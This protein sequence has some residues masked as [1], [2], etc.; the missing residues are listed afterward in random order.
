M[1]VAFTQEFVA[2]IFTDGDQQDIELSPLA[3]GNYV[4]I[5]NSTGQN[6]S[7]QGLVAQLF[8]PLGQRIGGEF[9]VETDTNGDQTAGSVTGLTGGGFVVSWRDGPSNEIRLQQFNADGTPA[10][11]ETTVAVTDYSTQTNPTVVALDDGGYS[12]IW[13]S[14]TLDNY[15]QNIVSQRYDAGGTPSGGLVLANTVTTGQQTLPEV[16]PLGSGYITTWLSNGTISAQRFNADGSKIGAEFTV[17]SAGTV[18]EPQVVTLAGGRFVIVW[19]TTDTDVSGYTDIAGRL[20]EADGSPVGD[21][22]K[23]NA[24]DLYHQYSPAVTA[25]PDGGFFVS[26]YTDT[27]DG[28]HQYEIL[29]QK[30]DSDGSPDPEGE[31]QLTDTVSYYPE[32]PSIIALSNGVI[33][34]AWDSPAVDS[35][36]DG[37]GVVMRLFT[38]DDS[39]LVAPQAPIVEG[40]STHLILDEADLNAGSVLLDSAVAV[41]DADNATFAG[42]MITLQRITEEDDFQNYQQAMQDVL[43][44]ANHGTGAGQIGV[45]GSTVSYEGVVIGTIVSN[46]VDGLDLAISLTAAANLVSVEA[47]IEALTYA[48]DSNDPNEQ[49]KLALLFEDGSGGSAKPNIITIDITPEND[50]AQPLGEGPDLV[51]STTTSTQSSPDVAALADGGWI[52]V[53]ESN[54]QDSNSYGIY[55]QRYDSDGAHVGPEF[56][57]NTTVNGS[58][59]TPSVAGIEGGPNA[60][61]WVITWED[62]TGSST[63]GYIRA[64][65]YD[66]NGAEVGPQLDVASD[67]NIYGQYTPEVAT[68]PD[69][70]FVVTWV[71]YSASTSNYDIRAQR[72]DASGAKDGAVIAVNVNDLSHQTNPVISTL[73][74]GG[75]VVTW[76]D[77]YGYDGDGYGVRAR[78][79]ADDGTPVSAEIAVNQSVTSTQFQPSVAALDDGSFV[80]A[81]ADSVV[82][83]SSYAVLGQK[84]AADG[85]TIGGQFLVNEHTQNNQQD[86]D[87]SALDGGGFMI[88][89]H[90][91]FDGGYGIVSQSYDASG[92]RID[93]EIV[94]DD[95]YSP[96]AVALARL[97]GG[98]V[99]SVFNVNDDGN[100]A[101]IHQRLIGDEGS[102]SDPSDDPKLFGFNSVRNVTEAEVNANPVLLDANGAVAL[103]DLN[104]SDFDGGRLEVSR[105]TTETY[106]SRIPAPDGD[107]QHVIGIQNEGNGSGQI[108][109]IGSSV[110]YGG[111]V[112]GTIASTNL[113]FTVNFNAGATV[114][115]V[116]TLLEHL[117]YSNTS[118]DPQDTRSFRIIL[119][120]GDGG[121]ATP[122]IVTVEIEPEAEGLAAA[123]DERLSNTNSNSTQRHPDVAALADGGYVVVWESYDQDGGITDYGIFAQQYGADGTPVGT[124]FQVTTETAG[125]QLD[126]AVVGLS[127][128]GYVVTWGDSGNAS[129]PGYDYLRAQV[130][131]AAGTPVGAEFQVEGPE[132]RYGTSPEITALSGGGF[133]VSWR[134]Y[135]LDN[136]YDI[137]VQRFDA[138]GTKVGSEV[139]VSVAPDSGQDFSSIAELTNGNL[140]VVWADTSAADGNA[141][142]VIGQIIDP[143]GAKVG[144]EFVVN[145]DVENNQYEASVAAL[146]TG[147][148]V[149]TWRNDNNPDGAG[150]GIM[151]Q[152]FA[153]DGSP[154]GEEFLV[155][156]LPANT[157]YEPV[158]VGQPGGGFAIAYTSNSGLDSSGYGIVMQQYAADGSRIDG[159]VLVNQEQHSSQDK[160]AI[161]VLAD[162]SLVIAWESQSNVYD[163]Q[164]IVHRVFGDPANF[165]G[166]S[167]SP[168]IEDLDERMDNG[169]ADVGTAS[170]IDNG[171]AV[172]DADSADFDGGSLS[173]SWL[174]HRSDGDEQLGVGAT[175]RVGLSGSDVLVDGVVIGSIDGTLNG[176]NGAD[177]QINFDND[178]TPDRVSALIEALTYANSAAS[179]V[180]GERVLGVLLTDGDGG[181]SEPASITIDIKSTY[182]APVISLTGLATTVTF[183]EDALQAAPQAINGAVDFDY[184][185]VAGLGGGYLE[186]DFSQGINLR[187][188]GRLD[189]LSVANLGNGTGQIGV[190]GD[191]ITYE[192]VEIGTI[193]ATENGLNG[194]NLRIDF[195][196]AADEAAVDALIEALRY[197]NTADGLAN[198]RDLNIRVYD[199][200]SANTGNQYVTLVNDPSDDGGLRPIGPEEQLNSYTENQ[201]A[202]PAIFATNDG[203]YVAVWESVYQDNGSSWGVYGQRYL[204]DGTPTGQ[205]FRVNTDTIHNQTQPAGVGLAD[206]GFAVVWTGSQKDGSGDG[207]FARFYDDSGVADTEFQ[208]NLQT[209]S[210]QNDPTIAQLS[211]GNVLIAWTA[212]T[213]AGSGDG[214]GYGISARLFSETGAAIS[215]SDIVLNSHTTN[216]QNEPSVAA[217][218]AGGFVAVWASD[219]SDSSGYGISGQ[220]F[221]ATGALVG[222]EFVVNTTV[223]SS[224]I[225]PD[226][227][228]LADGGFVVVWTDQS[229]QDGS[230]SGV[231]QQR[232]DASGAAVGGEVLVNAFTNS[233]QYNP[234]VEAL[235]D[236]GWIVVLADNYTFDPSGYGVVAQQFA[237]D[238]T[239]VDGQFLVNEETSGS[240][241]Y[242]NLTVLDDGRVAVAWSSP[243]SG[244]AGDGS[245]DGVFVRLL[246]DTTAPIASADPVLEGLASAL[247]IDEAD[248]N[249]GYVSLTSGAAAVSDSDSADFAGGTLEVTRVDSYSVADS[250]AAP[251]NSEQDDLSFVSANVAISG[252]DVLVGGVLVG[253]LSSDGQNGDNLVVSFNANATPERIE[254]LVESLSYRNISNDPV[255]SRTL[256]V[257]LSDG[258]GGVSE[259]SKIDLNVAPET[260]GF[261]PAG[262][263]AQVNT[264]TFSDQNESAVAGLVGGGHVVVWKSQYQDDPDSSN[265]GVFGQLF[266]ESGQPIGPEFQV[267][268]TFIGNQ[269]LPTVAALSGGGFV[270]GWH[271]SGAG[272]PSEALAQVFDASGMATGPELLLNEDTAGTQDHVQIAANDS[273]E[274]IA[275]W[276]D[277][278]G[279]SN[280]Y[281]IRGRLFDEGGNAIST[282]F[283]VSSSVDSTQYAPFVTAIEGGGWAVA[284]SGY[285]LDGPP[286]TYG[287]VAQLLN[288]DGSKNGTDFIVNSSAEG[289]QY[290]EGIAGLPGG[291]FVVIWHDREGF[292]G[293]SYGVFGQIYDAAGNPTGQEF[294]VN[295]VTANAQH[296]SDV[297]VLEDGTFVVAW[298][299][300][301][302]LDGSGTAVIGQHYAADG[303]RIDGAFVINEEESSTQYH[304]SLG[305]LASGGMVATWSSN[306]SASAGDGSS[307]GVFQRL[308]GDLG[309]VDLD[310]IPDL[311]AI[312][313][314]VSYLE[315]TVNASA[316]LIDANAAAVVSDPDNSGWDGGF[317]RADMVETSTAYSDQINAPDDLTQDILGLRISAGIT[318]SAGV[319]FFEGTEVATVS[320]NGL[321]G[322]PLVL[323]LNANATT[324]IVELLVEN[325]TYRNVS[326]DPEASRTIRI[327]VGDA[328]G[329]ASDPS[330]V[331]VSITAER[332][333]VSPV[334]DERQAN[335]TSDDY[336][337]GADVVAIDGGF[338]MVW[339]SHRQDNAPN[340]D[341]GIYGQRFDLDGNKVDGEFL[342]NTTVVGT[343]ENA[344]VIALADGGFAVIWVGPGASSTDIYMQRYGADALPVGGEQIVNSYQTSTQFQPDAV[345]LGNGDILVTWTSYNTS[346]GGGYDIYGQIHDGATGAPVS[347]EFRI[348]TETDSTQDYSSV[349]A[350][351]DGGF[352]VTWES[353]GDGSGSGV[354]GRRYVENSGVYSAPEDQFLIN[355]YTESTQDQPSVAGLTGG[356]I[357]AVWE[358]NGQDGSGNGVFGQI[359]DATGS[360]IAPEF[361]INEA[362]V[363]TQYQPEI[364]ALDH[365]GF[366][367]VYADNSGQD[368]SGFGVFA[369]QFDANGARID[370]PLM[371]NTEFSSTQNQPTVAALPGG[372]FVVGWKSNTSATAGDG[373]VDGVFYQIFGNSPPVVQDVTAEAVEDITY[374]FASDLFADGFDDED[375]QPLVEIRVDVLP[376]SGELLLDGSPVTP[377]TIISVA[378]LDA[379]ALTYVPVGDFNGADNFYWSGSDGLSFSPAQAQ[380]T[381]N[382]APVND[383]VT[384]EAGANTTIGEGS[385]LFRTIDLS[386]PDN[387]TYTITVDYGEGAGPTSFNTT[388]KTPNIS[389]HYESE[390]TYTVSVQ[391]DDNAGSV[392]TDSFT[393]TVNNTAPDARP[394][395]YTTSED[396]VL[397]DNLFEHNGGG[398][399]T[400]PGGDPF[401]VTQI[402]GVSYTPGASLVLPSGATIIVQANGDVS[403]DP[404]TSSSLQSLA[405]GETGSDSFTYTI[406]DD[407]GLTDSATVNVSIQG[408]DDNVEAQDDAFS[409]TEDT[410]VTGN[411]F[412]DNGNGADVDPEGDTLTITSVNGSTTLVGAPFLLSG[413]GVLNVAANGD[414][415]F[416][417]AG[418]YDEL[419]VG[420]SLTLSFTYVVQESGSMLTASATGLITITGVND[421]PVAGDNSAVTTLNTAT[422]AFDVLFNDYDVDGDTLSIGTFGQGA[423]GTVTIDGGL[424][425]YTPDSGFT[426]TDSF[427]YTVEDGQGGTDTATVNVTVNGPSNTAPVGVDDSYSTDEDSVLTVAASGVLANDSDADGDLLSANLHS[428]VSHGTVSLNSDGS[429]TYTPYAD[430]NGSDSFSYRTLDGNGGISG[431]TTVSLVVNPVNDAPVAVDDTISVDEDG[432]IAI[433]VLAND[434]DLDDDAVGVT[435]VGTANNGT[436]TFEGGVVSYIPDADYNGTDSFTYTVS[437]GQGGTDTATVS[438]TINGV[439]DAPVAEADSATTDEDTAITIASVLAND[440]DIDGDTL[441]VSGLDTTGTLGSVNDNGDGTFDYDPNGMFEALAV[442]ESATDT[443]TYTVSD[444]QGGTDTATV[445]VT[446]NGVNDA[447]VAEADSATTDEDTAI[448]IASVLANDSDI[449][450]DTLTVSGLDTTGTLGS[451]NDNGDGT[452][453]YDPNGMFE[454]L[455][456]G[457]SATDTFTYT[458]SDGQGGT[459]TAAV[460]VTI[461]GVNDAPV[462]DADSA[463]TDEDTAVDI[464][465]LGNDF[466][467][468]GDGLSVASVTQGAYG[469]VSIN[470]DGTLKYTPDADYFGTDS[471]TYALSDGN[472]GTDTGTVTVTVNSVN[473]DPVAEDDSYSTSFNTALTIAAAGVLTNDS[474]LEGDSLTS[475]VVAN[476]ANGTLTL[477]A[478]GSF[479][480]TPFSG[481]TGSDS[482]TYEASD[483]N[484]G[485]DTATVSIN[486]AS[487]GSRTVSVTN[488]S[489]TEGDTGSTP[490][491]ITLTRS[492]DLSAADTV[493]LNT[494]GVSATAG[495]DF[496]AATVTVTFAAGQ[497]T[498][499]TSVD[500]LGD[501]FV[502][503]PETLTLSLSDPGG[504]LAGLSL[505]DGTLTILDDDTAN[506]PPTA[507]DDNY[508]TEFGTT[509]SIDVNDGL[510]ANDE[511]ADGDP[512]SVHSFEVGTLGTLAVDA[513]GSFTYTPNAGLS[514]TETLSYTI[515][516][517]T[518]TATAEVTFTIE[519]PAPIE[520]FGTNGNDYLVGTDAD[521]IINSLGGRMDVIIG[522]G[523]ADE[524]VFA[525]TTANG[526]RETRTILDFTAGED[527]IDLGT[528]S[529]SM[530]RSVGDDL[531]LFLDQDRDVLI[532]R[533]VSDFDTN[534][535]V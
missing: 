164:D 419:G 381:I 480:Y 130:F 311:D 188:F 450:G 356:Q 51:N 306:T 361:R 484:G 195:V 488:V 69:G 349:T 265:S 369:Q 11:S 418:Q 161:D 147:G 309:D 170:L 398:A 290:A 216:T 155:N 400:D 328:D 121:T 329:S 141:Y 353:T 61:G 375:G 426:G 262:G 335:S 28:T 160:P 206:G 58:Q 461:D 119:S 472:G 264:T 239:M 117:T 50:A 269:A 305:A 342:V 114:E 403:Y 253:T 168:V 294:L 10:G 449:D 98:N 432:A 209:S 483:G 197:Q 125:N 215:G 250:F 240:Q 495:D 158:V 414:L 378:Q 213:S 267:N 23:V 284:W 107:L 423:N 219:G 501:L 491:G 277:Y 511:D 140:I 36:G 366:V 393:V 285:N 428:N 437:D 453:D 508:T 24:T 430:Y 362:R 163:S 222:A 364:V 113:A 91:Y 2:S 70:S 487:P 301:N 462:A 53:W 405:D 55:A 516:D 172:L 78:V 127:G 100:G 470:Q 204:S 105:L 456:V 431:I 234:K 220:R 351:A 283:S 179:P 9:F 340:S 521:E 60:G 279:A 413:G 166:P 268:S 256:R 350:T 333:G 307:Y 84:F 75:F 182:T 169:Q 142:G 22:F 126:P 112:I 174:N 247:T 514:G 445:S 187:E 334:F 212:N 337:N 370:G 175:V 281:S 236:G 134:G 424:F 490:V 377:G 186:A 429:F 198:E 211:N 225:Q 397:N 327:Q 16:A 116:E 489:A 148:F 15:T 81:W 324:A 313:P 331:N 159:S 308:F 37:R 436:V 13:Q 52:T 404:T 359:L 74:G 469:L 218:G 303:S 235:P 154:V 252:S 339:Q 99:I 354:F 505:N 189:T 295:E 150:A 531:Y 304:V 176:A 56:R 525:D 448:T 208:V 382:V 410:S 386:D 296:N 380:T 444:G 276:T 259:V 442:G 201:Q 203:G 502:E 355:T 3:N 178:A 73:A 291:G 205:E 66:A 391:V 499:T 110:T 376:T 325:L 336:Q 132:S 451:V 465:V 275:T 441:T 39:T 157:Q 318:I 41:S 315:N 109:V 34:T 20:Y 138:A 278:Y 26:Y 258:D 248:A 274:W 534:Y 229:G 1:T 207:V 106:L 523:G 68:N 64:Q 338:V 57:V 210:H 131:S 217:N 493:Q 38:P 288:A 5:W 286:N 467:V 238:G 79:F 194:N 478:D 17:S 392:S 420:D 395:Y 128:G 104:S 149:V 233:T 293:S 228:E 460:S 97:A 330:I 399:D 510:L 244:T 345:L 455:A 12:V 145:T 231:F 19:R 29:A 94:I 506:T 310:G 18:T 530:S 260:E 435:S 93:G 108:G 447:P 167:Q 237:A 422:S 137:M 388:S 529:V 35:D 118:N 95:S 457:E 515:T 221:D 101:G 389:N 518:D 85:S 367:V 481:F 476:P 524:F 144:V 226:V 363:N 245:S 65:V 59:D 390:G 459:D 136:D 326:D 251:D 421:N 214:S 520:L 72:F 87:V 31:I 463:T 146:T 200:A 401:A 504:N 452:F 458:V 152:L 193:D 512:I 153:A 320:S 482:F 507:V 120:D 368:A 346:D 48:S 254:L 466:D 243:T 497:A 143:S 272:G 412:D 82:D 533:D 32:M 173:L 46:G 371:V 474:D 115:A 190:S 372:G 227:T 77:H 223:T 443:F 89:W 492:G 509:L 438:V 402:N 289:N 299:D 407:E 196:A 162:G 241:N 439:N 171:V 486:V 409:V 494:V 522:G 406:A 21:A 282:E 385:T 500:I 156:D 27:V 528:A 123:L 54:G 92:A 6:G 135:S 383:P 224:Q 270:V 232:F 202:N 408:A 255:E 45:S 427:T 314:E 292:D 394:D 151:G 263:E 76:E 454:A 312:N 352:F 8:S 485:T 183:E 396:A 323:D 503:G 122:H 71:D 347:T 300:P 365:G 477:N 416:N 129:S 62:S 434:S 133:A 199:G 42:G 96:S 387:D 384:V 332:D 257:V 496:V 86:P 67:L 242:P 446:I 464:D 4:A 440:S 317:L 475:I 271:G 357:V 25:T 287:V 360:P 230:G 102:V 191:S 319:V 341:Y 180:N 468:D 302:A 321:A 177:L 519:E 322:A 280:G 417:A 415:S 433:P 181:T 527:V 103:S 348:N 266:D 14:Y 298:E 379:G 498:A 246:G 374:V 532:L 33:V 316:Q 471:F 273:G 535:F 184:T 185:G 90:G 261:A 513:D 425:T 473:D 249:A 111:A 63:Q 343:Q 44:V 358:S 83:G 526:M 517:G 139:V 479:V 192:G 124:E 165:A 88:A 297:I 49:V 80:I 373:S 43:G 47:L 40:V 30:F 7:G 344:K 411:V